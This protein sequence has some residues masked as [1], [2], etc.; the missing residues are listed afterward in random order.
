MSVVYYPQIGGVSAQFPVSTRFTRP[1]YANDVMNG[2][3]Y[4]MSTSAVA[5]VAWD[6]RYADLTDAEWQQLEQFFIG[7][8][9][10]FGAFT[11][12]G[13]RAAPSSYARRTRSARNVGGGRSDQRVT[14]AGEAFSNDRWPELV[15]VLFQ[16]LS[17]LR[18]PL[19][20]RTA[21]LRHDGDG[22]QAYPRRDGMVACLGQCRA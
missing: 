3:A 1:A 19:R 9:G 4:R 14:S 5:E 22:A 6:L 18:L 11:F 7:T 15:S 12:L 21:S 17:P 20:F 13:S 16:H 8:S 10:R 2:S